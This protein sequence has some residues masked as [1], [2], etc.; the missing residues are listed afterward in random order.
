MRAS[1][2][3]DDINATEDFTDAV[4]ER[5][6]IGRLADISDETFGVGF[7]RGYRSVELGL[8]TSANSDVTAFRRERLR[9]GQSNAT[10]TA[11]DERNF[12]RQSKLH[13]ISPEYVAVIA[14]I[15][16]HRAAG[17]ESGAIRDEERDQISNLARPPGAPKRVRAR[18]PCRR[19]CAIDAALA[20]LLL[21]QRCKQFGFDILR[22]HRIDADVV[23][24]DGIGNGLG[25]AHAGGVCHS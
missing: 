15:D 19:C 13:V 5:G 17:D 22:A 16:T 8:V 9:D 3:H 21:D 24:S 10:G 7:D 2:T 23:A 12:A 25:Q 18:E 1:I 4:D 6:D 11:A 20:H 14:A